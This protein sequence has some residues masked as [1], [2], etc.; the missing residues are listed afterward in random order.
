MELNLVWFDNYG[1]VPVIIL[2]Y[3]GN[4]VAVLVF[5]WSRVS[6]LSLCNL[7]VVCLCHC[8]SVMF[9]QVAG[10]RASVSETPDLIMVY[11][12]I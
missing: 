10:A 1:L 2:Q 11:S 8:E 4:V 12:T 7:S 9:L 6:D 3:S 5:A